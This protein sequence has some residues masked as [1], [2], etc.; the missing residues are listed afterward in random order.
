MKKAVSIGLLLFVCRAL[1]LA[2]TNL[3]IRLE[4]LINADFLKDSEVG[5]TVYDLTVGQQ[6][7]TYQDKK[8]FR[9]ASVQKLI[10]GITALDKLGSDY[11]LKTSL[12]HTGQ[13]ADGRLNGDLYVVGGF[14]SEF[15]DEGMNVLV[16]N[17]VM[18]GIKEINGR[19][20][21]DIS[22]KDSLY[23]GQGWPWDDNPYYFQ[24]YLS[25][26]MF[27]KGYVEVVARPSQKDSAAFVS[28][29]PV[30][31][32]YSLLNHTKT[33]VASAGK[34][35]AS[36]NWLDGGNEIIVKGNVSSVQ[37]DRVNMCTSQD[38]FMHTFRE[39][40]MRK[41]VIVPDYT[42]GECPKDSSVL[43]GEYE[44]TLEEVLL[45]AMKK[46]DNLSAEAMFYHL[47]ANTGEK[48]VSNEDATE[49]IEQTVRQLGYD[50]EKYRIVDGSG[51]SLYNYISSEL[52]LAFLKYAYGQETIFK[53]L[54][55]ALP[56]GGVDGTLRNRMKGGK[57]YK[58]VRAKTGSVTGVSSLAGYAETSDGHLLAFVIINQNVLTQQKAKTFQNLVCEELC[59]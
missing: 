18:A 48:H 51:I 53:T 6:L 35:E 25:P 47:A 34:F 58:N 21:G 10:T 5:I 36:R 8:L 39:R 23:W 22:M 20:Y 45:P 7:Y 40:L 1:V 30:S 33:K 29:T 57:A 19:L 38:F 43:L 12:Y 44:H 13:I 15:D 24:P 52:L 3:N 27:H 55:K 54:Y 28:C 9:P 59:R 42:F 11:R 37:S 56:V 49:V 32:F 2:Q 50:S 14:D 41:S 26:L 17:I 31:S 16:E 46:S 4:T